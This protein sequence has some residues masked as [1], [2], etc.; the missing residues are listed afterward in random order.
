MPTVKNCSPAFTSVRKLKV[1]QPKRRNT[2][3]REHCAL[4]NKLAYNLL[5]PAALTLAHLALA[6]A[7]RAALAAGENLFLA[8]F[9]GVVAGAVP[10]ILA[11]L[12][13]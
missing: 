1:Q 5:F 7:A 4:T 11:H 6:A 3:S 12:A 13:N 2:L 10:L 9:A 8:F